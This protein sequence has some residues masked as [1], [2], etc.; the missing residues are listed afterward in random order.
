[1][2]DLEAAVTQPTT[3]QERDGTMPTHRTAVKRQAEEA[4]QPRLHPGERILAGTAVACGPARPDAA[5]AVAVAVALVAEGLLGV[6]GPQPS[7]LFS[8]LLAAIA[9]GVPLLAAVFTCRPMYVA[10]S[11]MRLIGLPL[12]RLGGAPGALAFA[13]LLADVRVTD[14][15]SGR[16]GISVRC[17]IRGRRRTRLNV[18]RSWYPDFADVTTQLRQCGAMTEPERTP[19]PS[20]AN[21]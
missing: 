20:G 6:F 13:A 9:A 12:S 7:V 10:V 21:S 17:E 5:W 11:D 15:R 16:S 18:E 2:M 4:I 14:H 3:E 1:M 19:Y 8:G